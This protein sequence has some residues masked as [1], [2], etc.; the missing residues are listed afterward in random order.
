[1]KRIRI[2]MAALVVFLSGTAIVHAQGAGIEWDILNQEV[3]EL[4]RQG[5][6]AKAAVLAHKTLDVAVDNV[7]PDHPDV[8]TILENMAIMYRATG[9]AKEAVEL[10]QRAKRIRAIKR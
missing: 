3:M 2:V 5:N 1:M 6:Y 9:R 7:G 10:E 8:A 4:L